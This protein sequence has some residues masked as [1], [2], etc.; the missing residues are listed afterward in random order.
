MKLSKLFVIALLV[1]TLGVIGCG[2]DPAPEGNGGSGGN[3][4][5]GTG[6]DG[7]AG[8][9]GDG[10]GGT[11]SNGSVCDDCAN[12]DDIP[13]CEV[14]YDECDNPNEAACEAIGLACCATI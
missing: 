9:G 11:P 4:T 8:T 1:G 13:L 3:G 2:S 14:C 6:G 12:Q 5:A 7:T 10:T